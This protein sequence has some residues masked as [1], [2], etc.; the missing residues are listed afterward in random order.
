M[1]ISFFAIAA[2]QAQVLAA[3]RIGKHQIG[4]TFQEWLSISHELDQLA[5]TCKSRKSEDNFS[6]KL[7]SRLISDIRDGKRNKIGSPGDGRSFEWAFVNGR[8][9]IV[10]VMIPNPSAGKAA[11]G[12]NIQEELGFLTQKY[13]APTTDN[14]WSLPDGTM[15]LATEQIGEG[16]F[17]TVRHELQVVFV[18]KEYIDIEARKHRTRPNPYDH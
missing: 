17:G 1:A 2:L 18:S 15:I 13:G 6:C 16:L 7:E 5:V 14:T 11:P 9:A 4:E 10:T 3:T 8:L 12:A